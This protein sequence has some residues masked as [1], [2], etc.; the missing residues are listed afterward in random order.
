MKKS[1]GFSSLLIKMFNEWKWLFS[2]IRRYKLILFLYLL[3]G[4]LA[5]VMS[6]IVAVA[7]KY[8]I[9]AVVS[10]ENSMILKYGIPVILLAVFQH[11]FQAVA[12][13]LISVV[14][15][16]ANN[17][18]REEIYSH[19]IKAGW[20]DISHFHSGELLNR[21]ESDVA[22]VSGGAISFIPGVIT[23]FIQFAGA[24]IIVLIY[25]KV[26][27]LL[28]LASAPFLF[29]SS[30]F[31]VSTIRKYNK[32]SR[33][34]NGRVLSFTEESVQNI[35][36]IKAFD[37]TK[38]YISDF[39]ELLSQ[40]RKIKLSHDRFSILMT[41]CLS[42]IGVF[43]SYSCYGLG[44]YRLWQGAI[45]FGTMTM[46]LQLSGTL[47]SSFSSLASMVPSAVS[48]ATAAG[49]IMEITGFEEEADKDKELA[50]SIRDK[51]AETG[52]SFKIDNVSFKYSDGDEYVLKNISLDILPGETIALI[53]PSGEGKTTLLKLILGL[54]R[55]T[56][57]EISISLDEQNK[58]AVSDS[59]RRL[60]SYVP[61]TINIFS[62]TIADN[63][64]SVKKD[65]TDT[66]IIDVLKTVEL[67][68]L[69]ESLSDGI[70][71][72]LNENGN[73][74]SQGQLQRI[75]IA[76]ALL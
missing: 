22:S 39:A 53:G 36:L 48:I 27:A 4:V 58:L 65:A 44:I 12:S 32:K 73:N 52:V 59:T 62:G 30:K 34:I 28:A 66:E 14:S 26:L 38:D 8:L 9:D 42:L 40:Y 69:I 17:E 49:R 74:F 43:V 63:L 46:F 60:L 3:I 51:S 2:Y 75:S 56:E 23:K 41:L 64:R 1:A 70:Y 47:T 45:T 71:T 57:G 33:E 61:Q 20:A 54:I 76:R 55:P 50:V 67:M 13:W 29:L 18:I 37:L 24:L 7:G 68:P 16:K 6:L 21:L 25:D 10:H 15:S 35:Q 19:I 11:I 5:S 31:L 72:Q